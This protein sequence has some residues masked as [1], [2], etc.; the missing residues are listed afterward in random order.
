MLQ[1]V[2]AIYKM[3]GSMVR[4]PPDEDTPEKRVNKIFA[5]MDQ[6][7][8]GGGPVQRRADL[9]Y[10]CM[11]KTT[12]Q[13][14]ASHY[15]RVQRRLEKGSHDCSGIKPIRRSR[16]NYLT[17]SLSLLFSLLLYVCIHLF[18]PLIPLIC[19]RSFSLFNFL[20]LSSL[21]SYFLSHTP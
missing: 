10:S 3:V 21:N 14:R 6:V 20:F 4:L 8:S 12:G 9:F 15:G 13:R 2:D 1:I 5:M 16:I 19:Y 11:I 7:I 18:F 17:L